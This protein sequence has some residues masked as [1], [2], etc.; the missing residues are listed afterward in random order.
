[1]PC[2]VEAAD[3]QL[4][5]TNFGIVSI[6]SIVSTYCNYPVTVS[7]YYSKNSFCQGENVE[8]K[9]DVD[10]DPLKASLPDVVRSMTRQLDCTIHV[11]RG[12]LEVREDRKKMKGQSKVNVHE[13]IFSDYFNLKSWYVGW[14]AVLP[15]P[16]PPSSPK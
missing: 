9:F 10:V 2:E 8:I 12:P 11:V 6:V 1:M 4:I 14:V 16:P 5:F 7:I 13:L 15:P 3:F